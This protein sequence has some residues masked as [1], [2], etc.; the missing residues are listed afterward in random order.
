V[1]RY[2]LQNATYNNM[3]TWFWGASA[4]YFMY[5]IATFQFLSL[6]FGKPNAFWGGQV[7]VT[8]NATECEG[9]KN[10]HLSLLTQR[11][12]INSTVY[13]CTLYKRG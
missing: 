1:V 3:K 8:L 13:T 6:F 5:P 10:E 12:C 11:V 4:S 7:D 2:H 9:T